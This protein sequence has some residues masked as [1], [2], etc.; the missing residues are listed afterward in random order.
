MEFKA[1]LFSRFKNSRPCF[2]C[3]KNV[4]NN[5]IICEK[6][7]K[8]VSS[9]SPTQPLKLPNKISEPETSKFFYLKPTSPKNSYKK[10]K[11]TANFNNPNYLQSSVEKSL[12]ELSRYNDSSIDILKKKP[13]PKRQ[14]STS[15]FVFK[16]KSIKTNQKHYRKKSKQIEKSKYFRISKSPIPELRPSTHISKIFD[17][18]HN[19][20][21][22]NISETYKD[23]DNTLTDI[24]LFKEYL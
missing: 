21:Q 7:K 11:E 13:H 6:C 16:P 24:C 17:I 15:E 12:K 22:L 18:S 8:T 19:F 20:Y 23:H 10:L 1:S 4:K 2:L 14:K 9:K 3:S 5:E